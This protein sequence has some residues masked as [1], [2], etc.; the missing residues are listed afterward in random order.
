MQDY[1]AVLKQ[2]VHEYPL[3]DFMSNQQ[4][5]SA[6]FTVYTGPQGQAAIRAL[7]G[8][9]T[10]RVMAN[11]RSNATTTMIFAATKGHETPTRGEQGGAEA[12]ARL[13][14]QPPYLAM[15]FIKPQ[16]KD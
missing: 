15:T 6:T 14:P 16:F 5:I 4:E 13:V 1:T 2:V 8:Q 9:V 11:S 10:D 12:R 3:V 7:I